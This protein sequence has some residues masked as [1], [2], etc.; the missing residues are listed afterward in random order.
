MR[1][2]SY[3]TRIPIQNGIHLWLGSD[4]NLADIDWGNECIKSYP[5]HS[6]Q[7]QRLL[8]IAKDSFSEQ[9]VTEPTR[10]TET[11]FNILD[12]FFT[13]KKTIVNQVH[14]VPGIADHEAVF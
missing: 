12:L 13:N 1:L 7:C 3:I 6:A 9:V 5:A 2:Q 10:I 4:F 14:I 11:S 8:N